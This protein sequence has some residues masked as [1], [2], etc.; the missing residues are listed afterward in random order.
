MSTLIQTLPGWLP[1]PVRGLPSIARVAVPPRR[2]VAERW[3]KWRLLLGVAAL[4]ALGKI[5]HEPW[6]DEADSW[7][8]ARDATGPEF[9]HLF[10]YTGHPPLWYLILWPFARLGLPFQ[11]QAAIHLIIAVAAAGVLLFRSPLPVLLSGGYLLSLQFCY[12]HA[13]ISRGYA[14]MLLLLFASLAVRPRRQDYPARYG[15][16]VGLLFATE[17]FAFP[18]AGILAAEF[19]FEALRRGR[20]EGRAAIGR[21]TLVAMG[22]MVAG[23]GLTALSLR[24]MPDA[25]ALAL[26]AHHNPIAFWERLTEGFAPVGIYPG[27]MGDGGPM[28]AAGVLAV[29]AILATA[30]VV[31]RSTTALSFLAATMAWFYYLFACR[32]PGSF[33]HSA[34]FLPVVLAALWIAASDH[35]G[36]CWRSRR[37]GRDG[38]AAAGPWR[39]A[40]AWCKAAL[41]VSLIVSIC[42]TVNALWFDGRH[43]YSGGTRMSQFIVKRGLV[44][45]TIASDCPNTAESVAAYLPRTPFWLLPQDRRSRYPL[46]NREYERCLAWETRAPAPRGRTSSAG[47]RNAVA[48]I[49]SCCS[50]LPTRCPKASF[51]TCGF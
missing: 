30:R 8:A 7:I 12:Q 27:P 11:T 38:M 9:L 45:S 47:S 14:L 46:W 19:V 13:V 26:N 42:G 35:G 15:A 20:R 48:A 25:R 6:R 49:R 18:M 44:D 28:A 5:V 21:G 3:A 36:Q 43:A 40:D 10:G 23:A 22:L 37:Q 2:Q 33:W 50:S 31:S 29:V 24:P 16:L 4:A 1:W 32:Y 34:L 41:C 39:R 17:V 51:A